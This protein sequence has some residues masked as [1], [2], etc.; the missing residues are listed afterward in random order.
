MGAHYGIIPEME[1]RR[2]SVRIQL[3]LAAERCGDPNFSRLIWMPLGLKSDDER[4]Q[5]LID[6][7]Q[8]SSQAGSDLLQIKLEDL[9]TVI[10]A[11]LASKPKPKTNEHND[12][13]SARVYLVYDELDYP[14][15]RP[16]RRYLLEQKL[17]VLLPIDKTR[18][19]DF[20]EHQELL[21][22]ADAVMVYYGHA[23]DAWTWQKLRELQKLPGYGREKPLLAKAFY[24]S[25][26]PT[27]DKDDFYTNEA[28]VINGYEGFLP[29][30]L[31]PF[32]D[33]IK[34]AKGMLV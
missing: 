12:Q 26:P 15:T 1:R 5:A 13:G 23:S 10:C 28:L 19:R 24:L 25:A 33:Q 17:E 7:L 2:S 29:E 32:I 6:E 3:D 11:K 22:L 30:R 8:R 18:P 31:T 34:R 4:Q 14:E 27:E 20:Q 21:L 9:K 16:I